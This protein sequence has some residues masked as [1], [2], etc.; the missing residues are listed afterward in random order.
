MVYSTAAPGERMTLGSLVLN[1]PSVY[2]LKQA[3]RDGGF[4]LRVVH[5]S[6]NA[7]GLT[8]SWEPNGAAFR[9][10]LAWGSL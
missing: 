1:R 3:E 6:F 8:A 2:M 7:G 9:F 10:S 4:T 5:G